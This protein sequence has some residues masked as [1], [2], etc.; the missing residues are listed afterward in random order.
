MRVSVISPSRR[1]GVTTVSIFIAQVL[2]LLNN[3]KVCLTH[4][5]IDSDSINSYLELENHYD[6]TKSV[7]Q[8][9]KLLQV[10]A[11]SDEDLADY[12]INLYDN[13][14]IFE[15]ANSKVSAV[16]SLELLE[17]VLKNLPHEI[18]VVDVDSDI[19]TETI[20]NIIKESNVVVQVIDMA[21][22]VALKLK[23]WQKTDIYKEFEETGI[24]T[25]INRYES[26]ILPKRPLMKKL[27]LIPRRCCTLPYNPYIV[28]Y[29]NQ[30]NLHGMLDPIIQ[31]DYRVFQLYQPL[32]EMGRLISNHL[33]LK[34][35]DFGK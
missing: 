20:I 25:V 6:S 1:Q 5:S 3:S 16:K 17:Y 24:L 4:T 29:S 13:V 15:T 7:T 23:A 2:A 8:V 19:E 14:D 22:D 35:G 32:E 9:V 30:G 26:S 34:A 28:K 18:Q 21:A 33:G 10:E 11:I 31:K 27:G 12:C